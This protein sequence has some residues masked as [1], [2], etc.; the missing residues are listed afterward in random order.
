MISAASIARSLPGGRVIR[1]GAQV[2]ARDPRVKKRS[3][4]SLSV[5][6][7]GDNIRVHSHR[8]WDWR[9]A[10]AYVYQHL[11]LPAWKPKR[12][13]ALKRKPPLEARCQFLAEGL[14][15]VRHRRR[16]SGRQ[17]GLIVNDLCNVCDDSELARR[18]VEYA[19]EFR[20]AP[21]DLRAALQGLWRAYTADERA[22]IWKMTYAEYRVLGLRR[23]GCAEL[24]AAE[25]RRLTKERGNAKKRADRAAKRRL[26]DEYDA[27]QERGEVVG[28]RGG[29]ERSGM[30]RSPAA[31]AVADI[32]LTRRDI[33]KAR[34][35]QDAVNEIPS[36]RTAAPVSPMK[37]GDSKKPSLKKVQVI[38][39]RTLDPNKK[40]T[41]LVVG[42]SGSS[43][44]FLTLLNLKKFARGLEPPDRRWRWNMSP[45]ETE[46]FDA[47]VAETGGA[48][49]RRPSCYALRLVV[50]GTPSVAMPHEPATNL[51]AIG[52]V[53][54]LKGTGDD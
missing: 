20:I 45:E 33:H 17:F 10:Q 1:S 36:A 52:V 46:H 32:G 4:R 50:V 53:E 40:P 19:R 5:W 11:G 37:G 39:L 54:R 34:L 29:G 51:T 3:D 49:A 30:E 8:G 38:L 21:D 7:D 12:R 47:I 13:A 2:V 24:G 23:S 43:G 18:A 35:I 6:V 44:G 22:V 28:P 16:I 42:L 26:A 41:V 15:I 25:R 48:R 9:E 31:P 14:R 27:A